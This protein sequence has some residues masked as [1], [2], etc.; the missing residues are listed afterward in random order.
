VT[1]KKKQHIRSL[2]Y[3]VCKMAMSARFHIGTEMS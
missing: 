3:F 1:N 2:N